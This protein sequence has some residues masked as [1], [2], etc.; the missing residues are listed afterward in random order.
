VKRLCAACLARVDSSMLSRGLAKGLVAGTGGARRG[1]GMAVVVAGS[2]RAAAS[3]GV[4]SVA[5]GAVLKAHVVVGQQSKISTPQGIRS[6][7]IVQPTSKLSQRA[8]PMEENDLD[9]E[10][11]PVQDIKISKSG[12]IGLGDAEVEEEGEGHGGGA[13]ADAEEDEGA[14]ENFDIVRIHSVASTC[15]S[16]LASPPRF[17]RLFP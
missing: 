3:R 7:S 9:L 13:S 14:L 12:A 6:M 8:A 4:F 15:R 2:R 11:G 1:V 10:D 17:S 5:R 16:C